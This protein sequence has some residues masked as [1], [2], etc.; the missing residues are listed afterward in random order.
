MYTQCPECGV[1]CRVTVDIL[2]QAAGRVRC[3]GCGTAFNS[4][5]HLSEQRPDTTV[6]S[7]AVPETQVPELKPEEPGELEADTPPQSIST[8]QNTELLNTLDQLAGS[9]IRIEDTGV[10]WRVLDDD[11]VADEALVDTMV[12]DDPPEVVDEVRFDD[13]SPLPVDFDVGSET[14][15]PILESEPEPVIEAA[16]PAPGPEDGQVDL[17]FG[18]P[19]EWED[20]LGDLN[21]T[22][23]DAPG[24]L[25]AETEEPAADAPEEESPGEGLLVRA[26][27]HSDSVADEPLD[28]D[29]QF[30]IQ[31]EAMGID[32]S[33]LHEVVVEEAEE[34]GVEDDAKDIAAEFDDEIETVVDTIVLEM[35][36]K[37]EGESDEFFDTADGSDE[38]EVPEMTEEEKTINKMIDQELFNIAVED[39]DGS[40]SAIVQVPP[41]KNITAAKNDEA[42]LI[43]TIIMED[44]FVRGEQDEDKLVADNSTQSH[45]FDDLGISIALQKA[46]RGTLRRGQRETGPPGTG[47]I[48]GIIALLLVLILQ[49]MHQL[50]E[51]L[52]TVPAFNQAVGPVYRMLG[53]PM[54]P[55]WDVSGWRF[56]AT[57]GSTERGG[58]VEGTGEAVENDEVLTIYSRVGNNSNKALPYPLVHLSLTDRYEEIIGSRVLEPR[59]YLADNTDL[60]RPVSPG[61]TFNAVISIESPSEEAT[62]FKLNVCYRLASRQLRCVIEDFR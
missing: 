21:E 6:P 25:S 55:A 7:V 13:N 59:E 19:D 36:S 23:A 16:E 35:D 15:L 17:A 53:K 47:T 50:R 29:T 11:E 3:G 20:L 14:S 57:M 56:E 44:E 41:D 30:A 58:E 27:S 60:R 22:E 31:A 18:D 33:G 8:E 34:D 5:A 40:T 10:E 45:R 52:A 28:V 9:D 2:R 42:P 32:L 24:E 61:S 49:V 1:A 39:E 26:E 38:H 4:L 46:T 48:V 37:G 62:G 54:T 43:E 12:S 51:S